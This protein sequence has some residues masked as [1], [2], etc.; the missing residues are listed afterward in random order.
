MEKIW[1]KN[2]P[3]LVPHQIDP[4]RY[5][6]LIELI[7]ESIEKYADKVAYI[8]MGVEMTY[9]QIGEQSAHF[10][11]FLQKELQLKKGDRIA[12]QMPNVLQYPI[13]LFGAIRAGLVV[14]NTNPLYTP[15]EMEHQFSDAGVKALVVLANFADRL[16]KVLDKTP[17]EHVIITEVGDMMPFFRRTLTN[18]VVKNVK[19]MVP[20]YHL[21]KAIPFR[22]AL[23]KG[24]QHALTPI[25][26][27]KN[28]NAFIQYTGGTT[29]VAKGAEL[30]H[31]N[32][33]ANA[34][35]I[36]AWMSGKLIEGQELIITPLPM[37]HIF[38][39]TV[40]TFIFFAYG[41]KNLLIT[42]PRDLDALVKD[43][44]KYPITAMTGVNTLFNAIANHPEVGNVDFSHL[45]IAIA[46]ATA[47]QNAVAQKW[48]ETT[49]C[50]VLEGFGLTECSPVVSCNPLDGNEQVGTIGL[51]L[52]STEVMLADDNGEEVA[53][54]ERGELWVRGPQVMKGYWKR[55][56][57]T[58]DMITPEGWLKT[59][60]VAIIQPDGF[61]KIVDRKKD[62]ILVSGFNVYPNEVEDVIVGHPKVMEVA[63]IGIPDDKS[64]EAV[65]VFVIKK[66]ESLTKDELKAYCQEHLTG[67]KIPKHYEFRTELPKSPVGKILRKDLKAEE[68]AKIK[69]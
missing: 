26:V 13:A 59:G 15:R 36:K 68:A 33:I 37:Y 17:V 1:L 52:P 18:F 48:K 14:V 42:N 3:S 31:R 41:A 46:G 67:Y 32:V 62:M 45:K 5:A 29:G 58:A 39:L 9:R 69:A 65:K 64:G 23:A 28:E 43:F 27:D 6:S 24:R 21:P 19:K 60:D 49:G 40:N 63:A 10:A 34:E 57:A 11:A 30:T 56:E 35:Q 7:E 4:E 2:Y 38:S 51:P 53:E 12:I 8:H 44:K 25:K 61:L 54:G 66:D 22:Y 20:A 47:L 50:A 16:E 55:P